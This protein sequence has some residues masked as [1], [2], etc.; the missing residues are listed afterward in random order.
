[1]KKKVMLNE[2]VV[3]CGIPVIKPFLLDFIA[4][5]FRI[6]IDKK[7]L[8]PFG[9][10]ASGERNAKNRGFVRGLFVHPFFRLEKAVVIFFFVNKKT[11]KKK[12]D[13]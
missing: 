2:K 11:I 5:I 4:I 10:G 7:S 6:F 3:K 8:T 1:M 13:H 12:I 9:K